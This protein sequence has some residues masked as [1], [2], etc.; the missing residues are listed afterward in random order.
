MQINSFSQ[1]RFCTWPR[2]KSEGFR[3]SEMAYSLCL[4]LPLKLVLDDPEDQGVTNLIFQP[5]FCSNLSVH[6]SVVSNSI[7][8]GKK[9]GQIPVSVTEIPFSQSK[10]RQIAVPSNLSGPSISYCTTVFS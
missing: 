7:P 1:E 6:S 3:K 10:K 9:P 4:W 5:R 2:F 8:S